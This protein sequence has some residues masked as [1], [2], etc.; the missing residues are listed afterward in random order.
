MGSFIVNINVRTDQRQAVERE[1]RSL[2]PAA[3]WVTGAANGWIT[4]YEEQTSTQ[5]DRWIR[6]LTER[7]SAGVHVPA[8][9]FLV[10]DSDVLC[11][12]LFDDGRLLDEFNSCPDYFDDS[13]TGDAVRGRPD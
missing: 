3:A 8:I 13:V 5:D 7:V 2:K 12:W 1:L 9:A 11:Y 4:V 10:H 6:E